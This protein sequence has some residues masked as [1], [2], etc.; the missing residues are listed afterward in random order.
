MFELTIEKKDPSRKSPFW[1]LNN[2]I[3][4]KTEMDS[5]NRY[6]AWKK[7]DPFMY[8]TRDLMRAFYQE[9]RQIIPHFSELNIPNPQFIWKP[10]LPKLPDVI[11]FIGMVNL[12]IV[13]KQFRSVT[14][15]S[16]EHVNYL[17]IEFDAP[18]IVHVKEYHIMMP[19]VLRYFENAMHSSCIED[20]RRTP[21][22]INFNN[23]VLSEIPDAPIFQQKQALMNFEQHPGYI[24]HLPIPQSYCVRSDVAQKIVDADL[25]GVTLVHPDLRDGLFIM[26]GSDESVS[27]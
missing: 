10:P 17:P 25:C 21:S 7:K 16:D 20:K 1:L 8:Q 9:Q 11:R 24:T 3:S 26:P 27:L 2:P 22:K 4:L 6:V 13:S 12:V 15:F 5:S 14:E 19:R 18:N 23:L